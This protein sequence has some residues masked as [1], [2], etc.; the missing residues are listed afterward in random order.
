[1]KNK[2]F[3][4]MIL[5]CLITTVLFSSSVSANAIKSDDFTFNKETVEN[6]PILFLGDSITARYGLS[7]KDVDYMQ[8]LQQETGFY[9]ANNA[10]SGATYVTREDNND[11][12]HQVDKS[13]T[14]IRDCEIV[15][16]WLGTNDFSRHYPLGE[17]TDNPSNISQITTIC[18]AMRYNIDLIRE[19]NPEIKI[20]I[21]SPAYR[22]AG[23]NSLNLFLTD[24]IDTITL[25]CETLEVK[26]IK[27]YDLFGDSD[28]QNYLN[29][30]NL[31]FIEAGYRLI[32]D[33]ILGRI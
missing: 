2:I 32:A 23:K 10:V 20:M 29:P 1:M 9:Y 30:D 22:V 11:L 24:Y 27:T 21:L 8:F 33:R 3:S 13:R 16:I 7:D 14:L 31:H 5:I 4:I 15:S 12:Y 17:T 28:Y 26:H 25:M 18:G 6:K 19:I